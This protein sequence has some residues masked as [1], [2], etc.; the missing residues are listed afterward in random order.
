MKFDVVI[1]GAGAAGLHCAAVAGA[2][3][4]KVLLIDH[5][6]RPGKKILISGGGRSNFTNYYIEPEKYICEN[7]H[8]CKSA[9]SQYTQWDFIAL[10]E[11]HKI[12]YHEKTLGQLFCDNSAKELVAMLVKE[13]E[14]A[15][16]VFSFQTEVINTEKTSTTGY[17]V[18]TNKDKY[19]CKSLIIASGGLSMP[20][21]GATPFAYKVAEQFGL[22]VLPTRAGLVPFTL[23]PEL[24]T[25]LAE[26]SGVSIPVSVS[27]PRTS[28]NEDM[29][30]THRGLSGPAV[31]QASSYWLPGEDI[32]VDLYPTGNFDEVLEQAIAAQPMLQLKNFLSTLFAKR[33]VETF[34]QL[35]QIESMMLK[36][37][38]HKQK[39]NLSTSIHAWK[40]KPSGTEGYRTAEV[41]L[42]GVNTD[43]LSSKTMEVKDHPGL[44]FIGEA[45]DVTG[46]LGGYNFQWAWSSGYVAGMNC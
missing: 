17:S 28:F 7:R 6:K 46:W 5:A 39:A 11:K 32:T 43:H 31:L 44:F 18:I 36:Q 1:I 13:C 23:Q 10:V 38:N 41:T 4:K 3:G 37:L 20:K 45:V 12:P 34:L 16:V 9:L 2:Q 26:I 30:I 21:L 8:F 14:K 35:L 25:P 15:G 33:F 40:I 24:K 27:T 42:G 19:T 22:E 29:L